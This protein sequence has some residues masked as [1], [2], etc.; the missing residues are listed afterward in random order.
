MGIWNNIKATWKAKTTTEKIGGILDIISVVGGGLIGRDLGNIFSKD[1]NIFS[2]ICISITASGFGAV[3]GE[4]AS[5]KLHEDYAEPLG[6]LIDYAK[7]KAKE[8]AEDEQQYA[9]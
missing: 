6:T 8:G 2:R 4:M 1:K 7:N 3:I 5:K 9:G